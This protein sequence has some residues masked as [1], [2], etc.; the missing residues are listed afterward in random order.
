LSTPKDRLL[1]ILIYLKLAALQFAHDTLLGKLQL[2]ANKWS[3]VLLV[4]LHQTL[5]DLGM[6]PP[7]LRTPVETC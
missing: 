2:N 7:S 5:R 6:R 1:F 3:H 4:V